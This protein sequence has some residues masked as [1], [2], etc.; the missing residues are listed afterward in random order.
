M[1]N[2]EINTNV[3]PELHPDVLKL[4]E[5][6]LLGSELRDDHGQLT[7]R[8]SL[9]GTVGVSAYRDAREALEA[10][11]R[12]HSAV[13]DAEKAFIETTSNR[14]T[15]IRGR[16][17]AGLKA[18]AMRT[19]IMNLAQNEQELIETA[20]KGMKPAL[21]ASERAAKTARSAAEH[22]SKELD[23]MTDDKERIKPVGI[24]LATEI[25][26]HVK[27]LPTV[28]PEGAPEDAVTRYGFVVNA[29][30][31]VDVPTVAAVLRAPPYLSG[32]TPQQRA[33]LQKAAEMSWAGAQYNQLQ[34]VMKLA[35]RMENA[36]N[37]MSARLNKLKATM[38]TPMEK[39]NKRKD[40]FAKLANGGR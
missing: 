34:A 29:I 31:A 36:W 8:R 28:L 40:A 16:D 25:R 9:E 14:S 35:D 12:W 26:A 10:I 21:A 37:S 18:A 2:I 20:E 13:E 23:Q 17:N 19:N 24:A 39:T 33:E 15:V 27:S 38:A 30:R 4:H 7:G 6:A 22:L 1:E 3:S 11:Y 32:L 5:E